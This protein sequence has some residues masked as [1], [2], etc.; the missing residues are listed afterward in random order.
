MNARRRG[1]QLAA[2]GYKPPNSRR[3][4]SHASH[5]REEIAL[6][7]GQRAGRVVDELGD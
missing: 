4:G 2:A 7:A 1:S 5:I 3:R 6:L